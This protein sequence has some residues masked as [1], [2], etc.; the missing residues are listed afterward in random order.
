MLINYLLFGL[1]AG[2]LLNYLSDVLPATR[3][4][5]RPDWWP[6]TAAGL[7]DYF[8]RIRVI[9]VFAASL[10]GAYILYEYPP[11]DFSVVL[12]SIVLVFF[13]LVTV[14]DIEHRV[15]LHPVSIAGAIILSAIGLLRGHE[16]LN[17]MIGGAVG[18]GFMLTVYYLGDWL[19]RLMA[20]ARNEAW[21][22]TAL[23]FGDV[24][25]AGVIGLLAGWPG[26]IAA[27]FFGM[28]AAGVFSAVFLAFKLLSGKYSAFT[29]IPYAPFLS[30]GAVMT[31][32]LSIY[33]T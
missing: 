23:G 26:V 30:L 6:F 27:L 8:S 13:M 10:V 5:S 22:E 16:L 18:F 24:N 11:A 12:L 2:V 20:K 28:L 4:L 15:V 33:L 25:L 14:I 19:G 7:K 31:I 32:L 1:L 21:E 3:R 9:I 17:T 29:S